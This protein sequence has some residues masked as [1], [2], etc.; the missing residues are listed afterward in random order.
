MLLLSIRQFHSHFYIS[1]LIRRF[2]LFATCSNPHCCYSC[3]CFSSLLIFAPIIFTVFYFLLLIISISFIY[4]SFDCIFS[5][6][7]AV[8]I[9]TV[10]KFSLKIKFC[11]FRAAIYLC[12]SI[13]TATFIEN[14]FFLVMF[15]TNVCNCAALIRHLYLLAPPYFLCW[16]HPIITVFLLRS[17][18]FIFWLVFPLMI[19]ATATDLL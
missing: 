19:A 10:K 8:L 12:C 1:H 16:F 7:I 6:V 17:D 9:F 3:F 4:Y 11:F 15:R 5:I 18:V 2:L 13:T 14:Y